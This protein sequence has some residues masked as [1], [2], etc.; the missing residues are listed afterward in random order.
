[1]LVA[2][3]TSN[4]KEFMEDSAWVYKLNSDQPGHV[5]LI[6]E[7]SQMRV[8]AWNPELWTGK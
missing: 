5:P 6:V 4:E 7:G 8:A 2:E 1:V 3:H